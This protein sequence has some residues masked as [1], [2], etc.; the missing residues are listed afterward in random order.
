MDAKEF[1]EPCE[2]G[3]A[4][5]RHSLRAKEVRAFATMQHNQYEGRNSLKMWNMCRSPGMASES[6][7]D[8]TDS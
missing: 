1:E 2:R 4:K 3:L 6:E 8:D 5:L 7:E